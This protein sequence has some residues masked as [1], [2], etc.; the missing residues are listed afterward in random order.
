MFDHVDNEAE[1][2]I[3]WRITRRICR[4]LVGDLLLVR[5]HRRGRIRWQI[6]D[7]DSHTRS[8]WQVTAKQ[9]WQDTS[10]E[11]GPGRGRVAD[12][13]EAVA[14]MKGHHLMLCRSRGK[15]AKSAISEPEPL[16]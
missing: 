16:S 4:S 11:K 15:G 9:A 2:V 1:A 3:R 8:C 12:V 5:I 10:T 13:T 6:Y 7:R 14:E